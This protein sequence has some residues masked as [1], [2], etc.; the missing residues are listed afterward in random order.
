MKAYPNSKYIKDAHYNAA[1]SLEIIGRVDEANAL[2]E[3]YVQKW[4]KD[5]RLAWALLPHRRQLREHAR[6]PESDR[7]LRRAREELPER[8]QPGRAG[9][10]LQ[11]RVPLDR[12]RRPQGRRAQVRAVREEV[13]EPGRRR[14]G[15]LPGRRPVG[16]GERRRAPSTSTPATSRPTPASRPGGE[17]G[18]R[19]GGVL[20]DRH[21]QG[22][23]GRAWSATRRRV[24][25]RVR[26]V[27]RRSRRPAAWDRR[28]ATT[29]PTQRSA[30]WSSPSK[31]SR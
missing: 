6:A 4:P 25:R 20:Q 12:A 29:Q 28:D 21:A 24:E 26:S 14:A 8:R 3:S 31:R 2:F 5:E 22:A 9:R 13:P 7:Q 18:S 11:L 17:P 23:V 1:N 10:A 27:C 15:P 16:A 19:H 30:R